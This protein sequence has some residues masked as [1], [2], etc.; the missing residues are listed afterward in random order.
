[1]PAGILT[2]VHR[3]KYTELYFHLLFCMGV[4]LCLSHW[5]RNTGWGY[6]RTG[7]WGRYLA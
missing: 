2:E 3:H 5:G 4:K 1:M 7:H 6:S